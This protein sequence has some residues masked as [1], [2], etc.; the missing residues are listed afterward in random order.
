MRC[1]VLKMVKVNIAVSFDVTSCSLVEIYKLLKKNI[2]PSS[3]SKSEAVRSTK[4]IYQITECHKPEDHS[5][6]FSVS[7]SNYILR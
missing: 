1:E 6:K 7:M 2:S 3:T 4:I 5:L